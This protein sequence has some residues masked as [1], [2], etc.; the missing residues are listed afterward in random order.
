MR[1]V[2]PAA[3]GI[4]KRP[5]RVPHSLRMGHAAVMCVLLRTATEVLRFYSF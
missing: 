5:L 3:N 4:L 2:W 1:R